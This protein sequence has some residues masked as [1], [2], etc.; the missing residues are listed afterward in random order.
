MEEAYTMFLRVVAEVRD[1]RDWILCDC[2]AGVQLV[3]VCIR[4]EVGRSPLKAF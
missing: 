2:L 3:Q 4:D 1:T